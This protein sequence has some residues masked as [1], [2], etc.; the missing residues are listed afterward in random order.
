MRSLQPCTGS[1]EGSCS[2]GSLR[3]RLQKHVRNIFLDLIPRPWRN[4]GNG[5]W[6][7]P[8]TSGKGMLLDQPRSPEA[9]LL[10][11]Q[12]CGDAF[13]SDYTEMA[14]KFTAACLCA[15]LRWSLQGTQNFEIF[16]MISVCSNRSASLDTRMLPLSC[17]QG[18]NLIIVGTHRHGLGSR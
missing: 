6:T 2:L 7:L 9:C 17:S 15:C 14:R 11:L 13:R 18:S 3:E 5:T 12:I 4:T 1:R 10:R 16:S 8:M